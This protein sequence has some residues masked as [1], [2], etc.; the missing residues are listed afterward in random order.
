[1]TLFISEKSK[2]KSLAIFISY[3]GIAIFIAV[4]GIVYEQFSHN[5]F[6]AEMYFAWVWVLGFG[7]IPHAVLC[8]A[9]IKKVPGIISGSIYNLG[10]AFVTTRSIYI[11]VIDI[12]GTNNTKWVVTYT[13]VGIIFLVA[14]AMFYLTALLL[15][16]VDNEEKKI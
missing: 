15:S 11:G 12:Y 7:L 4:F 6:S 5:V 8:F 1:M 3:V 10:V 14:G 2:K 9:P 16:L 13:I